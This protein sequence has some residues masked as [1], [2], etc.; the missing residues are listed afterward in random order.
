MICLFVERE[1]RSTR[2]RVVVLNVKFGECR[3]DGL[4]CRFTM[5]DLETMVDMVKRRLKIAR[6]WPCWFL[7]T[8]LGS[9]ARFKPKPITLCSI[10]G[11]N[12]RT[13][14]DLLH[15]FSTQNKHRLSHEWLASTPRL[16][17]FIPSFQGPSY[18]G[19]LTWNTKVLTTRHSTQLSR[20]SETLP[21]LR[22]VLHT[23]CKYLQEHFVLL[24]AVGTIIELR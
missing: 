5:H 15:P 7:T 6:S 4:F 23:L 17:T 16:R 12:K 11:F 20:L 19:Q 10:F 14:Q 9:R 22:S 13:P 18:R 8:M 21:A 1:S 24:L 2:T 3:G